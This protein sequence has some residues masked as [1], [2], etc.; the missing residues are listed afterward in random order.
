MVDGSMAGLKERGD[1]PVSPDPGGRSDLAPV[2]LRRTMV[3][4]SGSV[5]IPTSV[6]G[7]VWSGLVIWLFVLPMIAITPTTPISVHRKHYFTNP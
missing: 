7:L 2:Q 6:S 5:M 4:L 3:H 1:Q